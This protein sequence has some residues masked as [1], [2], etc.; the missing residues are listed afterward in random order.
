MKHTAIP[1][2]IGKKLTLLTSGFCAGTPLAGLAR[3]SLRVALE[4]EKYFSSMESDWPPVAL[5]PTVFRV[6]GS[7]YLDFFLRRA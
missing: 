1:G 2:V 3:V 7:K 6:R 5:P 4:L